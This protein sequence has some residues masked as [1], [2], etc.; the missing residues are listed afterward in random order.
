MDEKISENQSSIDYRKEFEAIFEFAQKNP[1]AFINNKSRQNSDQYTFTFRLDGQNKIITV[2]NN[3]KTWRIVIPDEG[4]VSLKMVK[5]ID[6]IDYIEDLKDDKKTK[7]FLSILQKIKKTQPE[8]PKQQ[9]V[10]LRHEID[11]LGRFA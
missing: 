9:L 6:N 5:N 2:T 11:S 3:S 10:S 7:E 8:Q 4:K 1:T